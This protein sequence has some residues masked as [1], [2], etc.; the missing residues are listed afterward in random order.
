MLTLIR[1]V[2][3]RRDFQDS[4]LRIEQEHYWI[5]SV[6]ADKLFH[7]DFYGDEWTTSEVDVVYAAIR[8]EL[9]D[10]QIY[11]AFTDYREDKPNE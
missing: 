11:Y 9:R 6:D 8:K 10:N 1:G 2:L 5:D 4:I 7:I 3:K